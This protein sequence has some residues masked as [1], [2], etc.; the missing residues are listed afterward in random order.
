MIPTIGIMI[1]AY[2]FTRM[3]ELIMSSNSG[4]VV[5]L[6]AG[7]TILVDLIGITNLLLTSARPP[8]SPF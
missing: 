7:I 6:F 1:G 4:L 5:R 8:T 3:V 2:I